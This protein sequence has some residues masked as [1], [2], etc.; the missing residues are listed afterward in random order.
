MND[1]QEMKRTGLSVTRISQEIGIDR[2]TVRK[3]LDKPKNPTYGPRP[4]RPSILD[5]FKPFLKDR[6]AAGVWNAVVLM[7]E[8]KERGYQGG[9]T[10]LTDYLH[11]MRAEAD[12]V[13]VRRFETPPGK[14]AQVD[15]GDLG[16]ITFADQ[17]QKT[18]SGF[19]LTLGCSR[20]LFADVATDQKLP[21]LLR[22]HEAAFAQL[23]GVPE[24]ILYDNMKTVVLRTLTEGV[25]E[26]GEIRW[27]KTLQDFA[28]Y[29]G[30]TARLCRPYRPQT[31]GKVESSVRYLR[32]N[33][34]C[35]RTAQDLEDLA[36]QL[37]TWVA[38]VANVRVHGTTHLRV[39]QAW[40]EEKAH[41]Q[42]VGTRPSYP[43]V[44]EERRKVSHDAFVSFETNRYP[45]G[46]QA[47]DK[48]VFVQRVG[49]RLHIV[50]EHV[51]LVSHPVCTGKHQTI[52]AGAL[53]D[54]MPYGT[55]TC[56]RKAKIVITVGAPQV[57]ERSLTVYSEAAGYQD[58]E[59]AA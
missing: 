21:T 54:G 44:Q 41:L 45:V 9:Y 7:R 48:E 19:L 11:P 3:Y 35:G 30:F 40:Q 4:P 37:G 22:M 5:P 1:I 10:A 34:L 59:R 15:W 51:R 52:D 14:Q 39:D 42:A 58:S 46:W 8:L 38:E 56:V 29:W 26:R 28:R 43:L 24:E 36:R 47:A 23:G 20:A 53:H 2:K 12:R 55:D 17:T 16:T 31:K 57:E 50:C 33:F 13:A 6:M 25:D 18:I 32:Q 49:D 27:N